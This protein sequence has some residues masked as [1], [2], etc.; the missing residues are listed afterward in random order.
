V[1]SVAR[2]HASPRAFYVDKLAEGIATIAA[3]FYPKPVIVRLSDFKSNEYKKLIGGSRYEPDEENPMLGFRGAS[4]YI[5]DD[6]AEAFE[7]E[8]KAMKRVRDE[9]GLTN[10]E[11]MVPFVR[12]LGQA[13]RVI[14]LLAKHGL[15]RGE[16]GLRIIMMCEV[17]SN[18]ILAESS[19]S[20]STASRSARTT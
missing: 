16:N 4:R 5:A 6:F 14:E 2:G 18:A 15:K 1:E 10:V 20:T 11:I 7:M 19:C 13:E 17:P 12:T 9:M 8:C 3:A